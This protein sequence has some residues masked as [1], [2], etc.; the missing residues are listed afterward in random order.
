MNTQV[1]LCGMPGN[2]EGRA[3]MKRE[4]AVEASPLFVFLL[5]TPRRLALAAYCCC[6]R[7]ISTVQINQP[8]PFFSLA[9]FCSLTL[10]KGFGGRGDWRAC[11][12]PAMVFR[13]AVC[14][15][16]DLC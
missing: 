14:G 6:K 7:S 13:L 16:N 10:T 3:Q 1:E 4:A 8:I 15:V 11:L 2:H 5:T 12:I 9:C